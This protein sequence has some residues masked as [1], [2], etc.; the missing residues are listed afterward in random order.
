MR[1]S[2]PR[3]VRPIAASSRSTRGWGRDADDVVSISCDGCAMTGSTACDDCIVTF[4]VD[5]GTTESDGPVQGVDGGD[6]PGVALDASE[7]RAVQLFQAAG[8]APHLRHTG[9]LSLVGR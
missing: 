3:P 1:P 9:V 6:A 5:R 7:A 8:L 2:P 4:L